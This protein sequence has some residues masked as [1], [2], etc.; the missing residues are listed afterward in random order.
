MTEFDFSNGGRAA[1]RMTWKLT[2]SSFNFF[3]LIA[4]SLQQALD[5]IS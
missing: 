1:Y 3:H 5:K 2:D 4:D